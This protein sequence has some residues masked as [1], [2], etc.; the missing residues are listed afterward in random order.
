MSCLDSY[1][2]LI[3]AKYFVTISDFVS[4]VQVCKKFR[5]IIDTYHFN[6]IRLN[7][8]TFP[9]F[10]HIETL[11]VYSKEDEL[12][13]HS[14][15]YKRIF[16]YQVKYKKFKANASENAEYK[17]IKYTQK[18]RIS[19]GNEIPNEVTQLDEYCF[20]DTFDYDEDF[21][22]IE[23]GVMDSFEE[24]LKEKTQDTFLLLS[25][26]KSVNAIGDHCFSGCHCLQT[27][28]I[29]SSVTSI[30]NN[31]FEECTS[32]ASLAI[33]SDTIFRCSTKI[34]FVNKNVLLSLSVP[35]NSF[36][37]N[38]IPFECL[39]QFTSNKVVVPSTVTK[40]SH[41]CFEGLPLQQIAFQTNVC[42]LGNYC[43]KDCSELVQISL[44]HNL[45]HI[46]TS[47]FKKCEKLESFT[48]PSKI[49]HFGFFY[50]SEC[51]NLKK[52]D[53]EIKGDIF[54]YN[55]RIFYGETK[56]ISFVLP[57][58]ALQINGKALTE[59]PKIDIDDTVVIPKQIKVLQDHCFGRTIQLQ[60]LELLSSLNTIGDYCFFGCTSLSEVTISESV[61]NIC[62]GCFYECSS[63][64]R[65]V[66]P[67]RANRIGFLCFGYCYSLEEV[68]VPSTLLSIGKNSFK[69]CTLFSSIKVRKYNYNNSKLFD[70]DIQLG[71]ING[72]MVSKTLPLLTFGKNCFF[73]CDK[74]L[75]KCEIN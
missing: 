59:Y 9:F 74:M 39:F 75:E 26:P 14:T 41:N 63:L 67:K 31:C 2:L 54:V 29:P 21:E 42:S 71:T 24:K 70:E 35:S 69:W 43:F 38:E 40:I 55:D 50:L 66:L 64:R 48:I 12:F 27:I 37:V 15:I 1:S 60:K 56:L 20:S 47:C 46:G 58:K 6:P 51:S 23:A 8:H 62:D 16:W 65:I 45:T 49:V 52:L 53:I 25:I 73:G 10:S 34:C 32:L 33:D 4:L 30:G 11:H 7:K 18:D 28:S 44:P 68:I 61:T 3:V 13:T 72:K 36:K 19:F 5:E 17:S 57:L 22:K